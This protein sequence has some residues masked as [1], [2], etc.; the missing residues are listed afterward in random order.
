MDQIC[1]YKSVVTG[2]V[3]VKLIK[4]FMKGTR[5]LRYTMV[6]IIFSE[7]A[8]VC[9]Q[10]L[11]SFCFT[12]GGWLAFVCRWYQSSM[13]SRIQCISPNR[14]SRFSNW[15]KRILDITDII[16]WLH[17]IETSI[18][19]SDKLIPLI[20]ISA[21]VDTL[22]RPFIAPSKQ[23]NF[24]LARE[25]FHVTILTFI[26]TTC[27]SA[28]CSH[29]SPKQITQVFYFSDFMRPTPWNSLF[30]P[31]AHPPSDRHHSLLDW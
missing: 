16:L 31:K 26:I 3:S 10:N 29:F 8:Q 19:A 2:L 30:R 4:I 20:Y 25:V 12:F 9:S 1:E 13:E 17:L 23:T 22:V 14:C 7:N 18:C 5:I 6:F 15:T 27:D 28:R 11:I 24:K 21:L